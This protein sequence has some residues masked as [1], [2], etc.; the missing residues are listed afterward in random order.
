MVLER[1]KVKC[2]VEMVYFTGWWRVKLKE[3]YLYLINICWV[4]GIVVKK[5]RNVIEFKRI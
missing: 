2:D 5:F 1:S 4:L 3:K